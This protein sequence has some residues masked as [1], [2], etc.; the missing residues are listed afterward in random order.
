MSNVKNLYLSFFACI[1][2]VAIPFAGTRVPWIS[3]LRGNGALAW[4]GGCLF[5]FGWSFI[6]CIAQYSEA[7]KS[8]QPI[9]GAKIPKGIFYLFLFFLVLRYL[10]RKY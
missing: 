5:A 7:V 4:Y 10:L 2:F 9:P 6:Y 1:I 3:K 8:G